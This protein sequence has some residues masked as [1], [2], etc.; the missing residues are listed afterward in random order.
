M[1][2][3]DILA[4]LRCPQSGQGLRYATPDDLAGFPDAPFEGGLVTLDG[5]R[6][7]PIRNGLPHLVAEEAIPR[8]EGEAAP[9]GA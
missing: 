9:A 1:I 2:G 4:L 5:D 7:Y 8:R 6:L 3:N